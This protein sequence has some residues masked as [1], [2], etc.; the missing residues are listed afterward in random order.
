LTRCC[1]TALIIR[2]EFKAGGPSI[3]LG[4]L[5]PSVAAFSVCRGEVAIISI[6]IDNLS[7]LESLSTRERATPVYDLLRKILNVPVELRSETLSELMRA[8]GQHPCGDSIRST[9]RDFWSHDSISEAGLP[10]E[11]F[12]VRELLTR[13]VRHLLPVDEV[14]GDL[15]VLM[16]SLNL[17]E[18]DAR[19]VAAS[20]DALVAPWADMF[21]PSTFSILASCKILALRATNV[22]LSRDLIIFADDEDITKSPFFHLPSVVVGAYSK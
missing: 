3:F 8:I 7:N 13:A 6:T 10:D 4:T 21:R 17:K 22:A 9:L 11:A 14:E 12:L 5:L 2:F 1:T 19:W 18:S 16:D 20:P 15:Y